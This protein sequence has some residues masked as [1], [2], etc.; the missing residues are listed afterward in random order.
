MRELTAGD[1]LIVVDVQRDFCSGGSLAVPDG[2]EV[3]PVLNHWI[4]AA[5][6]AHVP[7]YASRDWHPKRH[8]SFDEIGGPW[9][10]HCV[11]DTEGAKFHPNLKLPRSARL[12]TKGVRFDRD[13]NSVFDE[14][15]LREELRR[16]EVRRLWLGGLAEDVCVRASVLD[17]LKEGFE[18]HVIEDA[19][20]PVRP[21]REEQVLEE[22]RLA[23]AAI[24]EGD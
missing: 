19:I 6:R 4:E 11:Q 21:A 15:G 20:R 24:E 18:V 9:P 17:A 5:D 1:A 16:Q 3:V 23:G 12:V 2:D 13:Q 7:I 22:M 14:T 8:V 10:P